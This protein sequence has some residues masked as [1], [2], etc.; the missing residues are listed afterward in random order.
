MFQTPMLANANNTE[1]REA[2]LGRIRVREDRTMAYANQPEEMD[3]NDDRSLDFDYRNERITDLGTA[4][5]PKT[6]LTVRFGEW[7]VPC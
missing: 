1:S 5:H 2:G 3:C 4:K 6:W 7:K